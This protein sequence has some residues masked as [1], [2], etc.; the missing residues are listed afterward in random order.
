MTSKAALGVTGMRY[1]PLSGDRPAAVDLLAAHA[2]G[3]HS[4][5]VERVLDVLRRVA[6]TQQRPDIG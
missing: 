5:L 3:A 4:A 2:T 1:R 6:R